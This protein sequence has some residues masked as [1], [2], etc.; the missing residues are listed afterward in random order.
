MQ[1]QG[2]YLE[3]VIFAFVNGLLAT[4]F[5]LHQ[6]YVLHF[7]INFLRKFGQ[8]QAFAERSLGY[9]PTKLFERYQSG[10]LSWKQAYRLREEAGYL[11]YT[12]L[13][14]VHVIRPL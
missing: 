2:E 5:Y 12:W 10:Q 7:F 14:E 13:K 8:S 9:N 1:H 11:T 6:E 4:F 3:V